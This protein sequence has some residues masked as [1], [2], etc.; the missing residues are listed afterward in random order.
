MQ[1]KTYIHS[2][3]ARSVNFR[4]VIRSDFFLLDTILDLVNIDINLNYL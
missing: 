1:L 3:V 2:V 4:S